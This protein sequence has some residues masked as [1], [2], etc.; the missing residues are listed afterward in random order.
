MKNNLLFTILIIFISINIQAQKLEK[1][2]GNKVITTKEY[3]IDNFEKIVLGETFEVELRKGNTPHI[4]ITI[5]SNIHDAIE[6]HINEG[7]LSFYLNKR[8]STRKEPIIN[9]TFTDSLNSITLTGKSQLKMFSKVDADD[10]TLTCDS[11]TEGSFQISCKKFEGAMTDKSK[12][13]LDLRADSAL[14][15]VSKSSKIEGHIDT[16]FIDINQSDKSI[17]KFSG[18]TKNLDLTITGRTDFKGTNFNTKNAIIQA[19]NY[20]DIL[21][22]SSSKLKLDLQNN[23]RI[24]I[25]GSPKIDIKDFKNNAS[26]FKK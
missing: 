21:I 6:H 19:K 10:F 3:T 4:S 22:K 12:I 24:Y 7:V 26:I 1:I 14:I 9:I 13:E 8:I 17:I 20:A 5:D 18:K 23:S 2:K 16:S 15:N 11:N 25:Y